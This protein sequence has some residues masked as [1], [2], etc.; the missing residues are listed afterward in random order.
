LIEDFF[1]FLEPAGTRARNRVVD[2]A[3][4]LC[5]QN[6][7]LSMKRPLQR[8]FRKGFDATEQKAKKTVSRRKGGPE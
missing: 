5:A 1:G 3:M 8:V 7:P 6:C 4:L 2:W